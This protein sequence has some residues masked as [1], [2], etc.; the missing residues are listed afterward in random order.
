MQISRNDLAL[1]IND[2]SKKMFTKFPCTFDSHEEIIYI[3][4]QSASPAKQE[5]IGIM[6]RRPSP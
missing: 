6:L 5:N 3:K 4:S 2:L 1:Y